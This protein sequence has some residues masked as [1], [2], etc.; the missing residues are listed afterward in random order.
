MN[1]AAFKEQFLI[2]P[3]VMQRS[4]RFAAILTIALGCLI[5]PVARAQL[6]TFAQ[7]FESGGGSAFSYTASGT[8]GAGGSARLGT[9][10]VAIY[11]QYMGITNL[12]ADLAGIQNAHLAFTSF[13]TLGPT[14]ASEGFN[15][16]FNGSGANAA[17]IT[18]TRDTPAAE[19]NGGRT[20]LLEA[21]FTPFVLSGSGGSGT[22]NAS[23][24]SG[25][26]AFTSDFLAFQGSVQRDL[27]LAL[28][29]I[30]PALSIGANGFFAAFRA[31][32][33]GTFSAQGFENLV[34]PGP[35]LEIRALPGAVQLSWTTNAVGYRLETNNALTLPAGWGV[36]TS[37]FNIVA[38]NYV[39]TNSTAGAA[40]FYRLHKP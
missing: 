39:V 6:T 37:T 27:A 3:Q 11:F 38:T 26:V 12:P 23:S 24:I 15:E 32:A 13:T 34:A 17:M 5:A 22:L 4:S 28:S 31:A 25:T 35:T 10:N 29:S 33:T 1:R 16:V 21:I 30:S 8:A 20:L 18:I 9:T 2:G 19:G 40:K 14:V 7:F 36:L